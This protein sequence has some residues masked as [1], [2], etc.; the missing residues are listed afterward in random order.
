M[1]LLYFL[2]RKIKKQ[3]ELYQ[4]LQAILKYNNLGTKVN[5][6]VKSIA[7]YLIMIKSFNENLDEFLTFIW[8]SIIL[9]YLNDPENKYVEM[10]TLD[11]ED[12]N[13]KIQNL[14]IKTKKE[15]TKFLDPCDLSYL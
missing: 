4:S 7:Q 5:E 10:E 15:T 13:T 11:T 2:P 3:W 9:P 6:Q 1:F 14:E 12:K 8:N